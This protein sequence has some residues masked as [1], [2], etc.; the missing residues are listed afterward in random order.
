MYTWIHRVGWIS[1]GRRNTK[2]LNIENVGRIEFSFPIVEF[3]RR[4]ISRIIIHNS[5]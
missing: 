3:F 5:N 1:L 4:L 2:G